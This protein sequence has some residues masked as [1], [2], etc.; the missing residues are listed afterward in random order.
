[1]CNSSVCLMLFTFTFPT[2]KACT[3]P[4]TAATALS[5]G[6]KQASS[7]WL[8]LVAFKSDFAH[9]D[10]T[11]CFWNVSYVYWIWILHAIQQHCLHWF[12]LFLLSQFGLW[13][14]FSLFKKCSFH[15]KLLLTT[16]FL[17]FYLYYLCFIMSSLINSHLVSFATFNTTLSSLFRRP[18]GE[19]NIW[20]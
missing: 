5:T 9:T 6:Q 20:L 13:N 4:L 15:F 18:L 8:V 3:R 11:W 19:V 10:L 16:V 2:T 7:F 17:H 1:M 14:K 12:C